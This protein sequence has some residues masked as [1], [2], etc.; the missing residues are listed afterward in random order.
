MVRAKNEDESPWVAAFY[1]YVVPLVFQVLWFGIAYW[2]LKK[3]GIPHPSYLMF[4]VQ[5]TVMGA[6]IGWDEFKLE[7]RNGR[8]RSD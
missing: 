1:D 4:G 8:E 7:R 5:A 2:C 3:S 6:M